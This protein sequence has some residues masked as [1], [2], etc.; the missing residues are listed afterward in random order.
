MTFL[1]EHLRGVTSQDLILQDWMTRSVQAHRNE[2]S[3]ND[4]DN[5]VQVMLI[6]LRTRVRETQ[7]VSQVVTGVNR[8][9]KTAVSKRQN[10]LKTNRNHKNFQ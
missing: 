1:V 5:F 10:V 4:I 9:A 3:L 8:D 7:L 6:E 2:V